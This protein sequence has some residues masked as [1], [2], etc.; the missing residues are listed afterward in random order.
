MRKQNKVAIIKILNNLEQNIKSDSKRH[1]YLFFKNDVLK[2]LE[3]KSKF[4]SDILTVRDKFIAHID[5]DPNGR[6]EY[7]KALSQIQVSEFIEVSNTII[8]IYCE[9][10]KAIKPV[11]IPYSYYN[12]DEFN[13]I[14]ECLRSLDKIEKNVTA[15]NIIIHEIDLLLQKVKELIK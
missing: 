14:Y 12:I 1:K 5:I 9:I 15:K 10:I 11:R 7:K 8:Q 13:F 4:I 3:S 6:N 2:W